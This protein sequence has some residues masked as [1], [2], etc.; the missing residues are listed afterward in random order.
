MQLSA[1]GTLSIPE[2]SAPG[3]GEEDITTDIGHEKG[4]H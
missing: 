3:D 1:D 2:R 4:G